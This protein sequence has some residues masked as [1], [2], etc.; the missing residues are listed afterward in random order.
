MYLPQNICGQLFTGANN[1]KKKLHTINHY[2]LVTSF[3]S[4]L[5]I[6]YTWLTKN[7]FNT[8]ISGCQTNNI[9]LNVMLSTCYHQLSKRNDFLLLHKWA[10]ASSNSWE[11]MLDFHAQILTNGKYKS[12][13]HRVV[14]N[15][16]ATRITIGTAHGPPLDAIVSAAPELVGEDNS[17]IYRAIKYGDYMQLQRSHELDGKSCLDRI[18]IWIKSAILT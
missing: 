13:I 5:I 8:C 15:N 7:Y 12:I 14:V 6:K 4:V 17:P 10:L 2:I 1:N 18:R 3:N 9:F 16:K 11:F